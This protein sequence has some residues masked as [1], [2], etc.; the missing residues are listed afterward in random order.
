MAQF[1]R[2]SGGMLG[3]SLH[4]LDRKQIA[5]ISKIMLTNT[6]SHLDEKRAEAGAHL[7]VF[8]HVAGHAELL[9]YGKNPDP[10]INAFI[11]QVGVEIK[12]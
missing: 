10:F 6:R 8:D 11:G 4:R 9:F 2:T 5:T 1:T 12:E 7:V 3:L